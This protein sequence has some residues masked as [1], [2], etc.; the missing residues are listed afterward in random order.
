MITKKSATAWV[1]GGAIGLSVLGGV[2]LASAQTPGPTPSASAP[3]ASVPVATPTVPS[4][5]N[6]N[7]PRGDV[8]MDCEDGPAFADSPNTAPSAPSAVSAD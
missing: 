1:V 5:A 8:P 3:A 6:T 7:P 2:T 4:T